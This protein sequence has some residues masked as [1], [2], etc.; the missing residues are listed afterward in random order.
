M[1]TFSALGYGFM[2]NTWMLVGAAV[3]VLGMLLVALGW[4]TV[5]RNQGLVTS[6]IY[7]YSR[8]PQYLGIILIATGWF[9]GWPTLLTGAMLPVVVYEYYR[10]AKKEEEE[11]AE[12]VGEESY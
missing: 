5:Y 9:I 6:G 1:L 4:V 10:L 11:V 3:T 8:H 2:M 12:E 7:R